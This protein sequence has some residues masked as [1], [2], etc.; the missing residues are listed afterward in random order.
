MTQLQHE[1]SVQSFVGP[2][3]LPSGLSFNAEPCGIRNSL[4]E[5]GASP[6]SVMLTATLDFG[7]KMEVK[8]LQDDV[9]RF[10]LE[11]RRVGHDRI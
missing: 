2:N 1:R 3:A 4:Q 7:Y 11:S 10:G 8:Y 5:P 9:Y 6:K